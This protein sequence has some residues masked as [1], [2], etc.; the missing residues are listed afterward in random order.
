MLVEFEPGQRVGLIGLGLILF[1]Y[2]TLVL[3]AYRPQFTMWIARAGAFLAV[4]RVGAL[5]FMVYT[6]SNQRLQVFGYLSVAFLMPELLWFPLNR[7]NNLPRLLSLSGALV[8]GSCLWAA[9]LAGM[10]RKVRAIW[11]VRE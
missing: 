3:C 10:I 4:T 5:W 1:C 6:T 11:S 9:L 8:V 2:V 7:D